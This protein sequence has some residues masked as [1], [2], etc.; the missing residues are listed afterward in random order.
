MA[1]N[2]GTAKVANHRRKTSNFEL[3]GTTAFIA[4]H[5]GNHFLLATVAFSQPCTFTVYD[6]LKNDTTVAQVQEKIRRY[7][8]LQ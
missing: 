6:S 4:I 8:S 7:A 2:G 5:H 1:C 3:M